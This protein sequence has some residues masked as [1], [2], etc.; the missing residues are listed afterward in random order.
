MDWSNS[1]PLLLRPPLLSIVDDGCVLCIHFLSR[2]LF[3]ICHISAMWKLLGQGL[4]LHHSKD[5]SHC[6]DNARFLIHWPTRELYYL[7]SLFLRYPNFSLNY[8]LFH[9]LI[10]STKS[11]EIWHF[12]FQK[13]ALKLFKPILPASDW[14]RNECA[15]NGFENS[16]PRCL[17][18]RGM[19]KK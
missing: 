14:F 18:K 1:L 11:R 9:H 12:L 15:S 17:K 13:E 16:T 3:L 7:S 2:S 6:R 19:D 8:P 10:L 4:N 5:L